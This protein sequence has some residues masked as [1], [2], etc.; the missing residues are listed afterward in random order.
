[1]DWNAIIGIAE[2]IGT[3]VVVISLGYVGVQIRQNTNLATGE[4]QRE[5]MNSFQ[6]QLD[7]IIE[8]PE[9][10]RWGLNGLDGLTDTEKFEFSLI[11]NQFLNQLE[12]PLRMLE[13]GL[14]TQ[15]NV[16]MYGNI[17]IVWLQAPGAW[18]IC[19]KTREYYFPL[20]RAYI[21]ARL[22]DPESLPPSIIELYPWARFSDQVTMSRAESPPNKAIETET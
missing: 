7:R 2:V 9:L 1:M 11:F 18:E 14:E 20:S 17:C 8:K 10:V 19:Q 6:S 21:E 22:R 12:Q 5:V 4:T 15:D 13:R 16:D 3:L